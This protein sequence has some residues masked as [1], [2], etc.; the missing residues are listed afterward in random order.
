MEQTHTFIFESIFIAYPS[1]YCSNKLWSSVQ[2]QNY[3]FII[4]LGN[5]GQDTWLKC[6]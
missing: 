4:V 3:V 6:G 1:I 2:L 5:Q